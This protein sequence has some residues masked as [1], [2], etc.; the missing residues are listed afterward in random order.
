MT[1]VQLLNPSLPLCQLG[2]GPC[3]DQEAE[4]L[5]W[6]DILGR[7]VHS[8]NPETSVHF[9]FATPSEV[10]FVYPTGPEKLLLGLGSGVYTS[11]RD[12]R[13]LMPLAMLELPDEHRLNDGKIDPDGRLWVGTICTAK[14]P[15][16]TAALYRLDGIELVEV[17][18]GYVNANGKGW[19]PDG[20]TMY[21]ADTDRHFVWQYDYDRGAMSSKRKFLDLGDASPDGLCVDAEGHILVALYGGGAIAVY[22]PSGELLETIAL[23]VANITSCAFGGTD[24]RTLFVTTAWDGLDTAQRRSSPLSGQIFSVTFDR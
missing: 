21:H 1:E 19:S 14:D 15:S 5:Y 12:G 9:S 7:H 10:S 17:E 2:E 22:A 13:N 18:R 20:R 8:Y 4:I 24:L 11:D 3:W 6:V 23:P 16:E